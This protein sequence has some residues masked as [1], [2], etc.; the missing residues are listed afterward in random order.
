[1]KALADASKRQV[2][3]C[4]ILEDDFEFKC[5]R[6]EFDK[7][8]SKLNHFIPN[9]DVVMLS[10]INEKSNFINISNIYKV[11]KADTTSGYIVKSDSIIY[12]FNIFKNCTNPPINCNTNQYAIDVAWQQIQSKLNWYIFKPYLGI[13][14]EKFTSDIESFRMK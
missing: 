1:M 11:I 8:I 5:S 7:N 10:S 12:L 9:W 4:L 14:S 13:Q 3:T 2:N 6:N